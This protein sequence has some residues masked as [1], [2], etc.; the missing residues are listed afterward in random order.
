MAT[1]QVELASPPTQAP[2][3]ETKHKLDY[4]DIPVLDFS[5]FDQPG[6]KEK[7]AAQLQ[8]A[9]ELNGFF[10]IVNFGLSQ[11]DLQR[12]WLLG[13]EIL[14]LPMEEKMKFRAKLE[15]GD[16]NGYR[17]LGSIEQFPGLRD[18]WEC[19]HVFK[20]NPEYQKE[21][22]DIVKD[23]YAEIEKFHRFVHQDVAYKVLRLIATVLELPED[24]M[25]NHHRYESSCSSF[26]RYMKYYPRT[27]EENDKYKHIYTRGHT[28]FGSVTFLFSQ[29][30]AGLELQ[31]RDGS[32]KAVRHIPGSIVVNTA[33]MLH[34]W[35]NGYLASC[36]HRVVSPPPEQAHMERFGL[37]YFLRPNDDARLQTVDSPLL[38]RLGLLDK[39]ER[40]ELEA[41]R[42]V[43]V[44]DWVPIQTKKNWTP[45][46]QQPQSQREFQ[47]LFH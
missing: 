16:Y 41:K 29:P 27:P 6:G 44:G 9:V 45:F 5:T 4:A 23:H 14:Q 18:N 34:F 20:F 24:F 11:D 7:L 28:D 19:Y 8:E 21:H 17:P 31:E 2:A 38:R 15:D 32:W 33:D 26:L 43:R 42:N 13:K 46:D 3:L 30:I 10:Y 22:P 39:K 37:I 25:V 35:T 1:T 47:S 12:Q 36:M 40:E